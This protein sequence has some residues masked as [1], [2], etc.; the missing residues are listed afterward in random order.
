[1]KFRAKLLVLSKRFPQKMLNL[2]ESNN[3]KSIDGQQMKIN[4]LGKRTE[5]LMNFL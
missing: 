1:M 3:L 4:L 2:K 5:F